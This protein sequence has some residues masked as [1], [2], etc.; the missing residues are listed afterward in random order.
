MGDS[1]REAAIRHFEGIGKILNGRRHEM[2]AMANMWA[3]SPKGCNH[4]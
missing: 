3:A 1:N 2:E 4:A